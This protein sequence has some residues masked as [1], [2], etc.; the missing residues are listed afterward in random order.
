MTAVQH[1]SERATIGESGAARGFRWVAALT[2]VLVLLQ[3]LLAGRGMFA[4][5]GLLETH[6]W[7]GNVT[8]LAVL[9]Q[10]A[11]AYLA[12][13]R[14]AFGGLE[15]GLSALL[16]VLVIAQLGLGYSGRESSAAASWHIPNGVLIFGVTAALLAR[17][18][19]RRSATTS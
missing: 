3:A 4:D 12:G 7:V 11:L 15:L 18:L 14:G 5:P 1:R 8:F 17:S 9:A 13:R 16:L 19:P 10:V 6:G 2:A